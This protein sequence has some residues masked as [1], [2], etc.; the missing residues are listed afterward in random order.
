MSDRTPVPAV[1]GW[2]TMDAERP[3]LEP[4]LEASA[5]EPQSAAG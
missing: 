2:F 4:T 5:A 3:A 1:E